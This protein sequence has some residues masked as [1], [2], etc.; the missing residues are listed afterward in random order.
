[1]KKILTAV[2]LLPLLLG[3]VMGGEPDK[4]QAG[5][6]NPNAD[7]RAEIAAALNAA[8]NN[9]QQVLLVFGA[10]WCPWCR[11]IHK[12]FKENAEIAKLLKKHFQ[13]VSVDIGRK[14]KNLD[15]NEKY[16][17]P[18]KNGIPVLV[19]LNADGKLLTIQETGSLEKNEGDNKGHD[20]QK[21]LAFLKQFVKE[22]VK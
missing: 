14:D 1:M 21:I 9:H 5:P 2:I 4:T 20:P 17:N 16:G 3:I 15:L 22:E 6:Y 8:K 18:I 7:A 11:V 13:V 19:V 10:N 12:M